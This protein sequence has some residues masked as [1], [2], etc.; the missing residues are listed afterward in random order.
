[1]VKSY[2]NQIRRVGNTEQDDKRRPNDS[3]TMVMEFGMFA[4][5]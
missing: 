3:Q 4:F 1:M 5:S 2:G